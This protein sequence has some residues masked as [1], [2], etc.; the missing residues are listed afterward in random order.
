MIVQDSGVD[1]RASYYN[2]VGRCGNQRAYAYGENPPASYDE[3]VQGYT[4][5]GRRVSSLKSRRQAPTK[6]GGKSTSRSRPGCGPPTDG[7]TSLFAGC[8]T[9]HTT[10]VEPQPWRLLERGRSP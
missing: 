8:Y 5:T 6:G 3:F 2:A 10:D 1:V 7:S 4:N 9:A